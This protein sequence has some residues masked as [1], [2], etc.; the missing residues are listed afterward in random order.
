ME[1]KKKIHGME[2]TV[3]KKEFRIA[4]HGLGLFRSCSP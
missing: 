1:R 2:A 4:S 3:S